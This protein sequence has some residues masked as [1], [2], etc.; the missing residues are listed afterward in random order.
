MGYNSPEEMEAAIQSHLDKHRG[1][2]VRLQMAEG[3]IQGKRLATR[4][5]EP[6]EWE[7]TCHLVDGLEIKADMVPVCHRAV[8]G[9]R[10]GIT[11]VQHLDPTSN[12]QKCQQLGV[13]CHRAWNGMCH[14]SPS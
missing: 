14:L 12:L 10:F 13:A 8:P 3:K 4:W 9:D 5:L 7:M 2:F 11:C 6:E 1:E